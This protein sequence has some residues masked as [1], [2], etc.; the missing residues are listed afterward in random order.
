M[1]DTYSEKVVRWHVYRSNDNFASSDPQAQ[2]KVYYY[3]RSH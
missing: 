3:E 1:D 2:Q